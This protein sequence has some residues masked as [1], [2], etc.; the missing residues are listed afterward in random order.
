[1]SSDHFAQVRHHFNDLASEDEEVRL[2]ASSAILSG[3]D[4]ASATDVEKALERLVKGLASGRKS[5]RIGYSITLTEV[6][7]GLFSKQNNNAN[8]VLLGGK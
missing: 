8:E 4:A 7:L 6:C 3:L 2:A 1:M 5:A